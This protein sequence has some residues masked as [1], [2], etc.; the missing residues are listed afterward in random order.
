MKK[1]K[2]KGFTL[3]ELLV[4][5]AILA[6]LATVAVVGYTLFTR[7]ANN[8]NALTELKQSADIVM[9]SVIAANGQ[10]DQ[11]ITCSGVKF[12]YNKGTGKV[13]FDDGIEAIPNGSR[14]NITGA[15]KRI[16]GDL[17]NVAGS[18]IYEKSGKIYYVTANNK[19]IALWESGQDPTTSDIDVEGILESFDLENAADVGYDEPEEKED[20]VILYFSLYS[21]S[22]ASGSFPNYIQVKKGTTLTFNRYYIEHDGIVDF[23]AN[24]GVLYH[25]TDP[26]DEIGSSGFI[27][28]VTLD[29]DM[30]VYLEFTY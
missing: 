5:I 21:D 9:S 1:I 24:N 27:G 30:H 15:M 19:G 6:V 11:S 28:D 13:V 20:C 23:I 25:Y 29:E 10:E 4:V 14:I 18:F 8:S 7:K 22:A 12:E 2:R 26:E 17:S 16:F 3:V